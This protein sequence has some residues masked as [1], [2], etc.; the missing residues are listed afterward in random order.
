LAESGCFKARASAISRIGGHSA[1]RSVR[2]VLQ[3]RAYA[4]DLQWLGVSLWLTA[5][6]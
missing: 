4:T 1:R 2:A 6:G 3:I 5:D